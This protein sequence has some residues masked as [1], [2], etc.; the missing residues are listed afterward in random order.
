M[1]AAVLA[2]LPSM[3]A[4]LGF[5]VNHLLWTPVAPSRFVRA[6]TDLARVVGMML[7]LG[8]VRLRFY[9][10]GRQV[11]TPAATPGT[12]STPETGRDAAA[13]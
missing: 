3:A 12:G 7:G 5:A 13:G 2:I 8:G 9:G 4:K 10:H 6:G 11:A 1:A